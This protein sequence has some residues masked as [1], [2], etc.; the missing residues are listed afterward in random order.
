M[1]E[2]NKHADLQ[3]R[4]QHRAA[5]SA[6]GQAGPGTDRASAAFS[7]GNEDRRETAP[8]QV[9]PH[10]VLGTIGGGPSCERGRSAG[11]GQGQQ[12]AAAPEPCSQKA[13]AGRALRCLKP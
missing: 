7:S 1:G 6:P 4:H 5:C 9:L 12:I 8:A 13:L 11:E 10:S 3:P 2:I